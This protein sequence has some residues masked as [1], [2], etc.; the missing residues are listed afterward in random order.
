M[1]PLVSLGPSSGRLLT[2]A[3]CRG[4][5]C[6]KSSCV[7]GEFSTWPRTQGDVWLGLHGRYHRQGVCR[8]KNRCCQDSRRDFPPAPSRR[9]RLKAWQPGLLFGGEAIGSEIVISLAMSRTA[10]TRL[11]RSISTAVDQSRSD[12][13]HHALSLPK[14]G[15]HGTCPSPVHPRALDFGRVPRSEIVGCPR[16][17]ARTP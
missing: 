5:R 9:R 1:V 8:W 2:I 14:T 13:L 11:P 17:M 7:R 16:L 3:V 15:L 6:S 12:H 10:S 4:R